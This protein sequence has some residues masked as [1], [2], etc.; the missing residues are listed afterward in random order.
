MPET[1]PDVVRIV[2]AAK[3]AVMS[4]EL[5]QGYTVEVRSGDTPYPLGDGSG[6]HHALIRAGH[7]GVGLRFKYD[8]G[9]DQ[10]HILGYW[11]LAP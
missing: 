9:R 8:E 2:G 4:A 3:L 11:T 1:C 5:R 6:T 7:S 10:F